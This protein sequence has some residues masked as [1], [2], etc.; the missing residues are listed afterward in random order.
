MTTLDQVIASNVTRLREAKR[1]TMN[2]LADRLGVSRHDV[3][4]YEGRR[5]DRP[6]RPF[7]WTE[8]VTLCYALEVTLYELVL[9][10]DS[11]TEVH[12]PA[13]G[14]LEVV[15]FVSLALGWP[16][17]NDLGFGLFGVPGDKLLDTVNLKN[18]ETWVQEE[19]DR[20]IEVL[21][22]AAAGFRD[23]ADLVQEIGEKHSGMTG[24]E[25]L[26]RYRGRTRTLPEILE[27][28]SDEEEE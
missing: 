26:E 25:M 17:R 27:I 5:A 1:W 15:N 16:R 10:A 22:G 24:R 6:Q 21:H 12:D 9:P 4:A 7:R 19:T 2:D 8:L 14:S 23:M 20:R 28:I 13:F 3:L 18:F 11:D